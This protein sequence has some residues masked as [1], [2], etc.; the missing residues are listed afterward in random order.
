[1]RSKKI[2][3][4]ADFSELVEHERERSERSNKPFSIVNINLSN[5]QKETNGAFPTCVL[6]V[7]STSIRTID[8]LAWNG[9]SSIYLL[10][11]VT[12]LQGAQIAVKKLRR[13]LQTELGKDS[14]AIDFTISAY[15]DS[16]PVVGSGKQPEVDRTAFSSKSSYYKMGFS[17]NP[18][19]SD[20]MAID[21]SLIY[22]LS[23]DSNHHNWQIRLKRAVDIFGSLVCLL[24]SAPIMMIIALAIKLTSKGPAIF[25]QTRLGYQGKTF[26]FLKFRTMYVNND[27]RIHREYLEKLIEGRH[28]EINTGDAKRPYYKIK[29]DPRITPLGKILRRSSLDE[30]PQLFNVLMGHMSLVGP[31]PPIPYEVD[32][33]QTWHKKRVLNVRPGITGLWQVSGRSQTTFDE[34]VRLDL[35]YAYNWSLWLDCKIMLQT[36]QAILSTKGAD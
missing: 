11:P 31:R 29:D 32:K 1:M 24:L 20:I 30:L 22:D 25:R 12:P 34:M 16:A 4:Q 18:Q 3:T 17:G 6:D 15:P 5:A 21:H 2:L 35:Y 36:L 33:Y 27:D 13:K 26:S 10:L 8:H 28:N 19:Q 7:I 14:H 23:C 9:N